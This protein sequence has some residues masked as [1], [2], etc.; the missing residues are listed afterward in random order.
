MQR[1]F[2]M[3]IGTIFIPD[4]FALI[5]CSVI[6]G[7][8]FIQLS[9]DNLYNNYDLKKIEA[10]LGIIFY[11]IFVILAFFY[12][13]Y[14]LNRKNN[15][16]PSIFNEVQTTKKNNL[17][18]TQNDYS[19]NSSPGAEMDNRESKNYEEGDVTQDNN[20]IDDQDD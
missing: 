6:S 17:D 13:I 14:H 8:F 12:Q 15:E 2:V 3:G 7:L 18:I 19:I 9:V 16:T 5:P 1:S 4:K 20:N 10:I 11:S